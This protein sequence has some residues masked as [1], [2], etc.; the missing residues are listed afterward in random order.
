[1]RVLPNRIKFDAATRDANGV[2]ER[3]SRLG[4]G[5]QALENVAEAVAMRLAS[6]VDPLG[7]EPR[8]QLTVAQIDGLF[9]PPVP[10]ESLEL[11]SVDEHRVGGEPDRL[12]C[13]HEN[14][15]AGRTKRPPDRDELGSEALARA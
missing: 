7:V 10:N 9:Q 5:G 12:A 4:V 14:A 1:M 6:L 15:L 11:P 13:R 3:A 2:L 8:Q